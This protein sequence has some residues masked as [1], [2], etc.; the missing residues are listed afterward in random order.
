MH[1]AFQASQV[2]NKLVNKDKSGIS[3]NKSAS[4]NLCL[5]TSSSST[6]PAHN[7]HPAPLAYSADFS[8]K[9][10]Y[11]GKLL[12]NDQTRYN[13]ERHEERNHQYQLN[14]VHNDSDESD[15]EEID[16]TSNGCIDFSNNDNNNNK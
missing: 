5:T 1:P 3:I 8:L 2:I 11:Q 14:S 13:N 4:L 12:N 15:S 6:L 10:A 7:I 9:T 16:L